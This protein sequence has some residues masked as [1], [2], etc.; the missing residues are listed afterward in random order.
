MI[1]ERF[2]NGPDN[3]ED[4]A[5]SVAVHPTTGNVYLTGH[6]E[7]RT[8]GLDYW[9][10]I[11]DS[12]GQKLYEARYD[13]PS[14]RGDNATAIAVD[15]IGSAYVTGRSF[16]G[17]VDP[18]ADFHTIKY[19][20]SLDVIWEA[21]YDGRRNGHDEPF[22]LAVNEAGSGGVYVTGRSQDSQTKK[23]K[24]HFDYYTVRYS[25]DTGELLNEARYNG[26][27]EGDDEARDIVINPSGD[28][29]VTGRSTGASGM[30]DFCTVKYDNNLQGETPVRHDNGEAVS[31]FADSDG[32][33]VTGKSGQNTDSDFLTIMYDTSLNPV[34]S[35]TFNA[36]SADEA[37]SVAVGNDGVFV[38]GFSTGPN[39]KDFFTIKYGPYGDPAQWQ[40]L[41]IARYDGSAQAD[42]MAV[43]II[44]DGS[45][46]AYVVGFTTAA[47]K[48]L[49]TL[50]YLKE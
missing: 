33:Y 17:N 37:T 47:S 7:G 49:T 44:V 29:F 9:T 26:F 20:N 22:A 6:S 16:R 23:S 50:K 11:V 1:W 28:V 36:G 25:I 46:H 5:T 31:V 21:R 32:V 12:S 2:Y 15:S 30:Y 34:W 38:S 24:L 4:K 35:H 41:W 13:G 45:G 8:T 48:D 18:H 42:D 10:L 14:H 40:P 19:D 43:S 27:G 39:G 3:G